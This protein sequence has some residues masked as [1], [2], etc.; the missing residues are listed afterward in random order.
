MSVGLLEASSGLWKELSPSLLVT[1]SAVVLVVTASAAVEMMRMSGL[2]GSPERFA[3][4]KEEHS[5]LPS[6]P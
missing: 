3:C 1:N 4:L 2:L 6:I 5:R